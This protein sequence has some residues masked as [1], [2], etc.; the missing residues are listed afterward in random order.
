MKK[1]IV[2]AMMAAVLLTGCNHMVIDTHYEFNKAYINY[3]DRV[4]EVSVKKWSSSDGEDIT[5]VADDGTV[6]MC[7]YMNCVMTNE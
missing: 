2:A 1:M 6:Y 5:I 4:V 3:G 7:S